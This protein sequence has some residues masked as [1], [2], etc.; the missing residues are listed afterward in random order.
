MKSMQ[1]NPDLQS[2]MCCAG[3]L[4]LSCV[5]SYVH[6]L[7]ARVEVNKVHSILFFRGETKCRLKCSEREDNIYIATYFIFSVLPLAHFFTAS[8]ISHRITYRT[9][10]YLLISSIFLLF[11]NRCRCKGINVLTLCTA[12]FLIT[13]LSSCLWKKKY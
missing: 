4:C 1:S 7:Y 13:W 9:T 8:I 6:C 11:C 12:L 5:A 10:E 2:S 3:F